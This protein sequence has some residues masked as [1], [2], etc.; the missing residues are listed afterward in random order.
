MKIVGT[1]H[2][3]LPA[4]LPCLGKKQR[5]DFWKDL[6]ANETTKDQRNGEKKDRQ[7]S[8]DLEEE[9]RKA[10]RR[11]KRFHRP[12]SYRKWDGR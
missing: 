2:L 5:S 11:V 9:F 3:G 12:R 10:M 4:Y 7:C 1:N 8:D 6:A